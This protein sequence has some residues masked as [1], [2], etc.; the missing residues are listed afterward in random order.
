MEAG[1]VDL[2][3]LPTLADEEGDGVVCWS[4]ILSLANERRLARTESEVGLT[5]CTSD[6]ED[7]IFVYMSISGNKVEELPP[8]V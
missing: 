7:G 5:G 2:A 4:E 1:W 6:L 8:E 3:A